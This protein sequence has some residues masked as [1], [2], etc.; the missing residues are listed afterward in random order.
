MPVLPEMYIRKTDK[1]QQSVFLLC[2]LLFVYH[3][4]LFCHKKTKLIVSKS[5]P[6]LY[7]K[8]IISI[9]QLK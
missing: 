3:I 9:T 8:Y 5:A 7:T 2:I 6:M 4:L 1:F